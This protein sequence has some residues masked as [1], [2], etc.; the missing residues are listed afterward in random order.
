MVSKAENVVGRH[1]V[2][3]GDQTVIDGPTH[4]T[5]FHAEWAQPTPLR[6]LDVEP[7]SPRMD[8]HEVGV[9]AGKGRPHPGRE[10]AAGHDEEVD[11]AGLVLKLARNRGPGQIDSNKIITEHL[12]EVGRQAGDD[13]YD[14]RM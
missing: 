7:A 2:R 9:D 11:V 14:R 5:A 12:G 8:A 1:P 4:R 13:L 10:V 6:V 3:P